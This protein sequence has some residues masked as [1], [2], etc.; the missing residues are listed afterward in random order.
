MRVPALLSKPNFLRLWLARGVSDTGSHVST[1][2]IPLTAVDVLGAGPFEMGLLAA[3]AVLPSLFFGLVAGAWVDRV[4]RR[5]IL[6]IADLGRFVLLGSIPVTAALHTLGLAQL[7]LVSFVARTLAVF[8]DVAHP[9]Y[10]PA[11]VEPENLVE[12]NSKLATSAAAASVVGPSLGGLLVQALSA[13]IAVAVDAGSFL[14][15]GVLVASIRGKEQAATQRGPRPHLRRDIGEGLRAVRGDPVLLTLTLSPGIANFAFGMSNALYVLYATRELAIDAGALG[16]AF[17]ATGAGALVGSLAAAPLAGRVGLGRMMVAAL[18]LLVVAQCL[19]P[20]AGWAGS[21]ALAWLVA[22][23]A[24]VG[25]SLTLLN[26]PTVSLR[27]SLTPMHLQGR[28][29]ATSRLV[30]AVTSPLGAM[31]GGVSAGVIGLQG[32][33]ALSA[34][35]LGVALA[36]VVLSPL[37]AIRSAPVPAPAP[38]AHPPHPARP[39]PAP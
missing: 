7:L 32:T 33:L 2:A 24:L 15:S 6:V 29:A 4:S 9:S 38:P 13:P 5:P 34:A 8:F 25:I 36:S 11:L 39:P 10:V 23:R 22:S 19:L 21:W 1:L 26:I 28:V 30:T 16:L 3:T 14:V 31:L 37:P 20:L 18:S 35:W 27:Q 17:A 12:A